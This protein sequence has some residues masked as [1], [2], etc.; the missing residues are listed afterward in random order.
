MCLSR[1][2]FLRKT[3]IFVHQQFPMTYFIKNICNWLA[4]D[5][6]HFQLYKNANA[7]VPNSPRLFPWTQ[8]FLIVRNVET[9][10]PSFLTDLFILLAISLSQFQ[11][12]PSIFRYFTR[13]LTF[14]HSGFCFGTVPDWRFHFIFFSAPKTSGIREKRLYQ[15]H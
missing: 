4:V 1:T 7:L 11:H 12:L 14:P 2:H 5:G 3:P 6:S 10:F 8:S 15:F 9:I 13:S